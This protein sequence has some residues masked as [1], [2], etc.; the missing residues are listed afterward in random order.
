M[1]QKR[2]SIICLSLLGLV[3][4]G[5]GNVSQEVDDDFSVCRL[6]LNQRNVKRANDPSFVYTLNNDISCYVVNESQFS[7]FEKKN[8]EDYFDQDG[9][10]VVNEKEFGINDISQYY[11]LD[12]V[13]VS[14]LDDS[15]VFGTFLL[16]NP[17]SHNREAVSYGPE[18]TIL[19]DD[20]KLTEKEFEDLYLEWVHSFDSQSFLEQI[21]AYISKIIQNGEYVSYEEPELVSLGRASTLQVVSNIRNSREVICSYRMSAEVFQGQ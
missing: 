4:S 12:G 10:I 7:A 11:D 17:L 16:K 3:L 5:M 6:D 18:F 20:E 2:A 9:V 21:L 19:E 15:Q 13:E 14:V 8:M 1:I